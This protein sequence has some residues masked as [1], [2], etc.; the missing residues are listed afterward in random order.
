M[1]ADS[2]IPA[3]ARTIA[4]EVIG[5]SDGSAWVTKHDAAD[6]PKMKDRSYVK[7]ATDKAEMRPLRRS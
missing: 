1:T 2:K 4:D 3:T 5:R 7:E 6:Q